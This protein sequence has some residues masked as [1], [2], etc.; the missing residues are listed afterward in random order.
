MLFLW[1]FGNNVEDLLGRARF[2]TLYLCS[3]VAA[4]ATAPFG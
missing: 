1:I 2:L 3:G 4:V